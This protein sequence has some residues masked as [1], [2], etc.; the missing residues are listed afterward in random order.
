M[1]EAVDLVF[2]SSDPLCMRVLGLLPCGCEG[3]SVE[4]VTE[5]NCGIH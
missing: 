4:E 1:K 3:A 5:R 2:V